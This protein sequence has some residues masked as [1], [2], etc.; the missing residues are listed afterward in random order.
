LLPA[1]RNRQEA[2]TASVQSSFKVPS[3]SQSLK[4]LGKSGDNEFG[5]YALTSVQRYLEKYLL[6]ILGDGTDAL[7]GC[8]RTQK[9]KPHKFLRN[10]GTLRE[11]GGPFTEA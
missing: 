10:G 1:C 5:G 7:F 3:E 4:E 11:L 2:E 9:F 8:R 6:V